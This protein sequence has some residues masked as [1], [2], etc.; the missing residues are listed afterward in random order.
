MKGI[1]RKKKTISCCKEKQFLH[2]DYWKNWVSRTKAPS[3]FSHQEESLS[4]DPEVLLYILNIQ[5]RLKFR[6]KTH[7]VGFQKIRWYKGPQ[8]NFWHHEFSALQGKPSRNTIPAHVSRR[9]TVAAQGSLPYF[10]TRQFSWKMV[11]MW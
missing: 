7:G 10:G 11:W 3:N 5:Q 2:W 9:K 8:K 4:D 6:G 1:N